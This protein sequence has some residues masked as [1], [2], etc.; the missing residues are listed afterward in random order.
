MK[1]ELDDEGDKGDARFTPRLLP[2]ICES[3]QSQSGRSAPPGIP[4]EGVPRVQ[5]QLWQQWGP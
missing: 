3:G 2:G 5:V 1:P 4:E